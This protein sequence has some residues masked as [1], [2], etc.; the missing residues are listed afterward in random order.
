MVFPAGQQGSPKAEKQLLHRLATVLPDNVTPILVTDAGFRGPWFRAVEAMGWQWLGRLR[1]RTQ[2]KPV[3]A[4]TA[5]DRWVPCKA[6]YEQYMGKTRDFELMDVTRSDPF[7]ARVVLH[8]KPSKGRKDRNRQGASARNSNRRKSAK[9]EREPWILMA[10]PEIKLS[11]RQVVTL[12][13][14][15]MQIELSFLDLK[16]HR[17][18]Q[19]FEDSFT[20]TARASKS[21]C[22]SVPWQRLPPG[23]W[24]RP[25]KAADGYVVNAPSHQAPA[26]LGNEAGTRSAGPT[27]VE[28]VFERTH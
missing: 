6:M 9:R 23:W 17:Y 21:F 26:V 18:G 11:M 20:A 15:R 2:L 24:A 7:R 25:A 19:G 16:S 12:Y 1:N 3:D 13:T 27:M 10:S 14:R 4:P 22:Y 5:P 28:H 8:G